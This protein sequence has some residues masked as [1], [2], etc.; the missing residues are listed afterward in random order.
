MIKNN[1]HAC[2]IYISSGEIL[3]RPLI[4][5]TWTHEPFANAKQRIFM[6]A[7]LSFGSNLERLTGRKTI[8]RLPIPKG[9]N[10]QGIGRRLFIF[11][12]NSLEEN[13]IKVLRSKL[14][15]EA[16]RC[17]ILAPSNYVANQIRDDIENSLPQ[18]IIFSGVDLESRKEEFVNTDSAV[19]VI[20]NRYDGI[21]FPNDDCRLLFID[22]LQKAVNLQ[23]F[24][25][26]T[27]MA[28]KLL[29]NERIQTRVLQ[30]IGRCSR[31]PKDYSAVIITGH[32][33]YLSD[34][35]RI[36]H[37]HPELQAELMFGIEQSQKIGVNDLIDNFRIFLEHKNEWAEANDQI[38]EKREEVTQQ[39]FPAMHELAKTVNHEINWQKAMWEKD[40]V[41]AF[42]DARDVLGELRDS[43]LKGYRALWH[44]LA[45]SSAK[46]EAID[47]D[48]SWESK[49][50]EQ[51]IKAK[52][53]TFGISWLSRLANSPN[54]RYRVEEE[55]Q[56]IASVQIENLEQYLE[57]LGNIE[58]RKFCRREREISEGLRP[59]TGK[60]FEQANMLLGKHLGF[61]AELCS[62]RTAA[63]DVLWLIGSTAIVFED[64]ANAGEESIIDIKKARQ[65]ALHSNW[66][67]D[68]FPNMVD[69]KVLVVLVTP[70]KKANKDAIKF[71]KNVCYWK[72]DEFLAWSET[73][74]C[75]ARELRRE[76]PGIGN[77]D[78]RT[79][80]SI[81]LKNIKADVYE[82]SSWLSQQ[83]ASEY[84]GNTG[85]PESGSK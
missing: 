15:E 41:K 70:A 3:I 46:L 26:M 45:G 25:L 11:P 22:N 61:E 39:Q 34:Q 82:L 57:E 68:K 31:G 24:F 67:R 9:W 69:L 85:K 80:A 7:T 66:A 64:H 44:Y 8:P 47:S 43:E 63:P 65:T 17:L 75:A 18:C 14:I 81:K 59:N 84:L 2:H 76:F 28:A 35:K 27:R 73:A 40:Y 38:L 20:A 54:V 74:L 29:F 52:N 5:P 10:K 56:N 58:N 19:A 30:A 78:W 1:L 36:K 55:I 50:R 77:L 33:N 71:L 79:S 12:E 72:L 60:L 13:D 4:P 83:V 21:D 16:G 37:F 42:D 51:F 48:G 49:A 32:L 23:E 62:K 53:A 6:S